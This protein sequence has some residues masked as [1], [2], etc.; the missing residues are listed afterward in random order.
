[1]RAGTLN[2]RVTLQQQSTTSDAYGQRLLEWSDV[3]TVWAN[4]RTINGKEYA[5]S[6]QEVSGVT[7]SIRIRYRSGINAGMRVLYGTTIYN[8]KAVLPDESGREYI[9]LAVESGVNNG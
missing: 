8:I 5:T 3:A 7:T 1:M 2:R 9:D 4:I 6:G